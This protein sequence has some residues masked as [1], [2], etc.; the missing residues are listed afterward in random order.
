MPARTQRPVDFAV[1]VGSAHRASIDTPFDAAPGC[2]DRSQREGLKFG[3]KRRI[4]QIGC[5]R[6][7]TDDRERTPLAP[8]HSHPPHPRTSLAPLASSHPLRC[9]RAIPDTPAARPSAT[10]RPTCDASCTAAAD[11]PQRSIPVGA[12]GTRR[13][14]RG[15][16]GCRSPARPNCRRRPT[17]RSP[18][19]AVTSPATRRSAASIT[20]WKIGAAPVT[21][22]EFLSGVRSKLPTQTPTV[23]CL[24]Y[25]TV[26]LSW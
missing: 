15:R 2:R 19:C 25:P 26:Q 8:S 1:R 11:A 9:R 12:W 4:D 23:T 10:P 16:T 22:L 14:Q 5:A 21:P 24:E 20:P 6:S 3:S 13:W 18:P 7:R 17:I